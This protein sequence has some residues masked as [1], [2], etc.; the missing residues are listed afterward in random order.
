MSGSSAS[1][2]PPGD[3]REYGGEGAERDEAVGNLASTVGVL[4]V[5]MGATL[6]LSL[7]PRK[8]GG[9]VTQ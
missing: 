6:V 9:D 7:S 4:L 5:L 2:L 8:A 3:R 1:S